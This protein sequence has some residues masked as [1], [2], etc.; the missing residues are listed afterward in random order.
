MGYNT[1]V[2]I[3]NDALGSLKEDTT[4]NKRLYSAILQQGGAPSKPIELNIGNHVNGCLVVEQHHADHCVPIL[5]GGNHAWL[6]E[7]CFVRWSAADPEK[8]LLEAL[9]KKWGYELSQKR[10]G[11]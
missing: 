5:V 9:A 2:L 4:F 3:L 1:S 10:T 11:K 6:I 7:K 8:S